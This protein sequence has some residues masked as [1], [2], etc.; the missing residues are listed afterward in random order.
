MLLPWIAAYATGAKTV[1]QPLGW[2]SFRG[3]RG[4][5]TSD[6]IPMSQLVALAPSKLG[7]LEVAEGVQWR[8]VV[9]LQVH[10]IEPI[11]TTGA[12]IGA[13]IAMSVMMLS[14]M[15]AVA[16]VADGKDPTPA[17]NVAVAVGSVTVDAAASADAD[18]DTGG[19]PVR[20]PKG[21]PAVL[22]TAD[23]TGG[24]LGV[25]PLFS[26][27][28]RRRESIKLVFAG[29]AGFVDAGGVTG[30]AGIGLR[31]GDFVELSAR[32][33]ALRFDDPLGP[34]QGAS[35]A[36]PLLL[37]GGRLA[38]HIDGDGDRRTAFVLGG[39]LLLGSVPGVTSL[40]E[41]GFVVGPRFGISDKMFASLLFEPSVVIPQRAAYGEPSA[42]GQFMLS[43]EF[44]FAL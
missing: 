33:R 36:A 27:A 11:R 20:S 22:V 6:W 15:A 10:N 21:S 30:S 29:E 4:K 44:G 18:A 26:G 14:A 41:L 1:G 35:S 34:I 32:V 19:A 24:A 5:W 28:A 2:V 17:L 9:G 7:T 37:Y 23:G 13:P 8:D 42:V 40:T 43:A 16:A 38:F 25:T 39:E 3:P 12:I 31:A